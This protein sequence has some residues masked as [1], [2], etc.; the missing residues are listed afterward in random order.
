MTIPNVIMRWCIKPAT[1]KWCEKGIDN[2]QA[3]VVVMFWN[4]GNAQHR[5]WNVQQYY[6]PD[7][8]VKQG[9][10][11]LDRNPYSAPGRGRKAKLSPTDTRQRYLLV[12]RF[13]ALEQRRRHLTTTYPD[14]LLIEQHIEE[15]ILGIVMDMSKVG[16]VPPTWLTKLDTLSM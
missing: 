1:C 6:H 16:G 15:Q 4:K 13:H 9:L 8:W 14:R 12:R 11:Y 7:C 3:M 2:R 10:D 5:G